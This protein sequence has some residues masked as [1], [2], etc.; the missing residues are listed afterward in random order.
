MTAPTEIPP[1]PEPYEPPSDC[2]KRWDIYD[3]ADELA[4]I[5][6]MISLMAAGQTDLSLQDVCGLLQGLESRLWT[7]G[8]R[9]GSVGP[10]PDYK[11]V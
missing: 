2:V 5:P 9:G 10:W 4:D 3:I 8:L 7:A 11:E 1:M 6:G